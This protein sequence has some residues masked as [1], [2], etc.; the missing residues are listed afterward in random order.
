MQF[1]NVNGAAERQIT[2]KKPEPSKE[3]M[4]IQSHVPRHVMRNNLYA[5]SMETLPHRMEVIRLYAA[6]E[7]LKAHGLTRTFYLISHIT[8][9]RRQTAHERRRLSLTLSSARHYLTALVRHKGISRPPSLETVKKAW[10]IDTGEPFEVNWMLP[11]DQMYCSLSLPLSLPL[12]S[13]FVKLALT[14]ST[15]TVGSSE[16]ASM[17]ILTLSFLSSHFV[18]QRVS[19]EWPLMPSPRAARSFQDPGGELSAFFVRRIMF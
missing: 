2:G 8:C 17:Y 10:F 3:L 19:W 15:E 16:A 9:I 7:K 14:R 11:P 4:A 5:D 6:S 18:Q 12:S 13:L 1:F